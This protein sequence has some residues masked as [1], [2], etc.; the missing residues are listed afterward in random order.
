MG[1]L[2]RHQPAHLTPAI[3]G[4]RLS[5]GAPVTVGASE[6][7]MTPPP[8]PGGNGFPCA[9]LSGRAMLMPQRDGATDNRASRWRPSLTTSH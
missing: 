7:A 8:G 9:A 6:L 1:L 5:P 3:A 4:S 2:I